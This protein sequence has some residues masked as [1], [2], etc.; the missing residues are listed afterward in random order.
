L[1]EF[2]SRREDSQRLRE[3]STF[4]AE[5]VVPRVR[6]GSRENVVDAPQEVRPL[7]GGTSHY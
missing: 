4:Q 7:P 5:W 6:E 2:I 1:K 3:P